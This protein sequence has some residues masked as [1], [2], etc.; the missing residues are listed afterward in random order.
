MISD[1]LIITVKIADM[2]F[3]LGIKRRDEYRYRQASKNIG[4]WVNAYKEKFPDLPMD[5]IIRM[6]VFQF[7]MS[8]ENLRCTCKY[9]DESFPDIQALESRDCSCNP[10]GSE[11][12]KH[13]PI[14]NLE[15]TPSSLKENRVE[16]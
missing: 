3:K 14:L 12:G 6:T 4:L 13:K 16:E 9:C 11:N 8:I 5:E 2:A 10:D 15:F 1:R 7:A